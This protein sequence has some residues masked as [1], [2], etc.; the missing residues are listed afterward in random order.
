MKRMLACALAAV[1]VAGGVAAASEAEARPPH[2]RHYDGRHYDGRHDGRYYHHRRDD[3]DDGAAIAAG[4]VGL[5]LGAAL[6]S[7]WNDN[8]RS[9]DRG[10]HRQP[11]YG[12]GRGYSG[13]SGY[14]GYYAPRPYNRT[15]RTTRYWDPYYGHVQRT[16]CW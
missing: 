10:Y 2:Q 9:Y 5:A 14:S 15:C 8:G 13:Y 6:A 4:V 7:G 12:Y 11:G 3:D 16:R 1:T